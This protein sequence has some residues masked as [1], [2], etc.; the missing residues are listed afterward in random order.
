MS[1]AL[2]CVFIAAVLPY[3]ATAVA[4]AGG[5]MPQ[6]ENRRPRLW[7]ETLSGVPQRAHWAQ[8]NSFEV[9]PAFAA[10]VI[11]CTVQHAPQARVD[12]LALA[13]VAFRVAYLGCYLADFALPRTLTWIGGSACTV[14]LFLLNA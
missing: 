5:R 9:F 3:V 12:A 8:L 10:A 2:W 11:V 7:L 6:R 1:L 14:W 4:K 13:F